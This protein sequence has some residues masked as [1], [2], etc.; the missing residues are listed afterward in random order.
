MQQ[1]CRV[2]C[3]QSDFSQRI[4]RV[5][6]LTAAQSAWS[7]REE[8]IALGEEELD[9]PRLGWARLLGEPVMIGRTQ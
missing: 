5:M 6:H 2:P 1:R 8:Q 9:A 7:L 4:R 3:L